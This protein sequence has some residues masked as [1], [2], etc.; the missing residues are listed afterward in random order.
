MAALSLERAKAAPL[1][2]WLSM[3]SVM[4][5]PRIPEII[6]P[7]FQNVATLAAPFIPAFREFTERFPSFPRSM[8]NLRSL[9]L[10]VDDKEDWDLSIDPF[11][12]L[13]P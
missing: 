6:T 11:E 12:S 4:Q 9:T 13:T 3:N 8:P 10:G 2:I 5:N 7:H 1:V